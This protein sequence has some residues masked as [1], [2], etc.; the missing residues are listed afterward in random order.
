MLHRDQS[1]AWKRQEIRT[2]HAFLE[3]P[4]EAEAEA[5]RLDGSL[6]NTMVIVAK[7]STLWHLM[8]ICVGGLP[9]HF[10]LLH[11]AVG[12]P[13]ERRV[14]HA[15]YDLMPSFNFSSDILQRVPRRLAVL[16]H[17]TS[18]GATGRDRSGSRSRCGRSGNTPGS[19]SG[20]WRRSW[21]ITSETSGLSERQRGETG[22][23]QL[24]SS[25]G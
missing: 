1:H 9:P 4:N 2:V 18:G 14:L 17:R 19:R 24:T 22:I 5:A 6:W 23:I 10:E 13:D 12:T 7:V 20:T 8:R 16:E 11:G 3:K 15:I 25:G 21:W